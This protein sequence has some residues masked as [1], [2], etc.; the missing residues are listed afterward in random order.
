MGYDNTKH[1]RTYRKNKKTTMIIYLGADHAGFKLKEKIKKH[2]T[3]RYDKYEVV[4]FGALQYDEKDDYPDFVRP[5]AEAVAKD[6]E[7][8]GIIIGGSG[9]GEAMCA[10]KVPGIR[11][12]VCYFF[13]EQSIKL[14]REHNNAN[15]LSL[16]A[17]FLSDEEALKAVQL[18]LDIPF[19]G[20]ERHIRRLAKY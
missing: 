17:R 8:R 4:D 12:S 6:T 1:H 14:S 7:S 5:V 13:N 3:Y 16:G 20:E 2:L 19:S 11:A 10:N 18:W 15:I 9:Q